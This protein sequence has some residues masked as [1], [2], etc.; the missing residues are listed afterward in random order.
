M[1][2][3]DNHGT[4]APWTGIITV[5][6]FTTCGT[7]LKEYQCRKYTLCQIL[8]SNMLMVVIVTAYEASLGDVSNFETF[9]TSLEFFMKFANFQY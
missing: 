1:T 4:E 6:D 2:D 8:P 3:H 7:I 9:M 5:T